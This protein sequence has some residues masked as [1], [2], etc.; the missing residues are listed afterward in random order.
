MKWFKYV[1]HLVHVLLAQDRTSNVL[2]HLQ[3]VR[4]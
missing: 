4:R 2:V 3:D 1:P